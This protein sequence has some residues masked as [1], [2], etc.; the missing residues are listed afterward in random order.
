LTHRLTIVPADWNNI[1]NVKEQ[2]RW[3]QKSEATMTEINPPRLV[4]R[5]WHRWCF[6]SSV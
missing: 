3:H 5:Q 2:L 6:W 4:D 1:S